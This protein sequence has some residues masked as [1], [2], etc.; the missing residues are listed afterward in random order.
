M[1]K[2]FKTSKQFVI[3]IFIILLL[4]KATHAHTCQNDIYSIEIMMNSIGQHESIHTLFLD[5][6]MWNSLLKK[7]S[8][9]ETDCIRM[10]LLLKRGSDAAPSEMLSFAVG[11]ALDNNPEIVLEI[12]IG[13]FA[14]Y[15]ICGGV[16]VDDAR[17]KT[18]TEASLAIKK[19]IESV[20]HVEKKELI[21]SRDLCISKLKDSIL[22]MK[23]FYTK[24]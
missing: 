1:N 24:Q 17:Y 8:T 15:D 20:Q 19:R 16:D 3:F 14:V 9:G 6:N 4:P 2:A 13:G 5:N 18:F 23:F 21:Q 11:E 12:A 22:H 7:I 10:A